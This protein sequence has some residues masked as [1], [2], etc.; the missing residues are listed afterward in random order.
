MKLTPEKVAQCLNLPISTLERW[1]RQGRIPVTR[2]DE[3]YVFQRSILQK[4]AEKHNLT[5]I[6]PEDKTSGKERTQPVGDVYD[7]LAEAMA[8]GGIFYNV[9]G[10]TVHGVLESAVQKVPLASQDDRQ[11]LIEHLLEREELASTGIGKG[12]AIPHPRTPLKD[13]A[14]HS[15]ITTCFLD[16]QIDFHAVD[17]LQVFVIF[18]LLS[19]SV[20][21]HLHL[22][23]RLAFCLRDN[24]FVRFLK[25]V[26]ESDLLLSEIARIEQQ[27][28]KKM[29]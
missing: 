15:M 10:D 13:I 11:A 25:T 21:G 18:I 19:P 6:M 20:K 1:I 5:F 2:A 28:D 16:Q 27:L 9:P 26:P 12:V 22:L 7:T 24:A 3:Q 29:L 14:S 17:D 4:W 23:S 8:F